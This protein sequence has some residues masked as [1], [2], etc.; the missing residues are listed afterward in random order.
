L[1]EAEKKLGPVVSDNGNFIFDVDFGPINDP[2]KL[3]HALKVIPGVVE[4]GLFVEMADIV[5]VGRREG[6]RKLKRQ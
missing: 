6:V 3:N 5:Y 4:T 2:K 1:R